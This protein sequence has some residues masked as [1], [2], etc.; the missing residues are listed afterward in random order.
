M[1]Q[2]FVDLLTYLGIPA[3]AILT[4]VLAV[5]LFK[6]AFDYQ[7]SSRELRSKDLENSIKV[8]KE[9]SE[10]VDSRL[11]K[12]IIGRLEMQEFKTATGL[13]IH[14]KTRRRVLAEFVDRHEGSINW[15][16]LKRSADFWEVENGAV[17]MVEKRGTVIFYGLTSAFAVLLFIAS[18]AM[19]VGSWWVAHETKSFSQSGPFFIV[20]VELQVTYYILFFLFMVPLI[21]RDRIRNALERDANT[22]G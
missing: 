6:Q 1:K 15:P 12:V 16:T 2:T 3:P 7:K 21:N 8:I 10:D 13:E 5:Y 14:S 17:K 19:L 11:R 4:L 9:L 20:V 18:L 22:D